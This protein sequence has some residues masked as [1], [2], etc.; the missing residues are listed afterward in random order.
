MGGPGGLTAAILRSRYVPAPAP[1]S[2]AAPRRILVVKLF[3]LGDM[4]NITPALRALR[5]RYPAARIDVLATRVGAAGLAR[6]PHIDDVIIFDKTLFDQVGGLASPRALLAG[7]RFALTLRRRRYDVLVLLH[8]LITTWGTLKYMVLALW[9]GAPVRAGLDNGRGWFLTHRARDR[10]FG[11]VNERRYWLDV[12]ATLGA[13]SDD[14]RPDFTVTDADRAAAQKLLGPTSGPV[15]VIHPTNGPYAPK[16]QWAP[17]RFAAV[18]DR[19]AREHGATIVLAGVASEAERIAAVERAMATP[20]INLA[21][22]TE[23]PVLAGLLQRADLVIGNDSAVCHLAAALGTP[24]LA[25]FGPANDRAWAPYG[26]QPVVL[27]LNEQQQP[28]LP[29]SRVLTVRGADPHAPCLYTGYGPGNPHG[30][31]NCRCLDLID[32]NRIA[33]LAAHLLAR[34]ALCAAT[35]AN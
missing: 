27:P 32:A 8:H 15:I 4:L 1:P 6:S 17:E 3:T 5:A 33:G 22:R 18:A 23:L 30:C 35:A 14:E 2:P 16:R 10:G 34:H 20:A 13:V 9:S 28:C 25:I 12:V 19:L 7:L 11:A 31:P 26:A 29:T 24:T 21:G